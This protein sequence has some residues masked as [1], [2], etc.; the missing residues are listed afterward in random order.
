MFKSSGHDRSSEA[1]IVVSFLVRTDFALLVSSLQ[2][3]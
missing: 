3:G 2:F 1:G